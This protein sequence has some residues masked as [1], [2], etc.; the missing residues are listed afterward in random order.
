MLKKTFVL[1]FAATLLLSACA[2]SAAAYGAAGNTLSVTG[3]G[4]VSVAPDVAYVSIG[5]HTE[6]S[7][8]GVAVANNANQV[9]SVMA[10]LRESGVA[11][12][13]LQTN[14]FSVYSYQDFDFEGNPIGT[15]F[16]VDNTVTV[17]VRDLGR[18]GQL[19][20]SAINAGANS[21][22]GIQFAREDQ[23]AAQAEARELAV[24]D[25]QSQAEELAGLTDVTL[26]NLVS[27]SYSVS[28]PYDYYY[29]Y[30][31]GGGGGAAETADTSIVPGMITVT[32]SVYL[33]YELK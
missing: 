20:D 32:V 25:A 3:V 5:V 14:N 9:E 31:M 16:S 11:D 24:A 8:V 6:S 1:L 13:D 21:I 27:V 33:A 23:D 4:T 2:P 19:L 12:A 7:D 17:T 10:A 29:P 18:M 30:G 15:T 22:W 28:S 26:G